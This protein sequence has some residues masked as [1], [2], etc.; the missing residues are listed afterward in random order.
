MTCSRNFR[1]VVQAGCLGLI[2]AL[3]VVG[4]GGSESPGPKPD[5][6][7]GSEVGTAKPNLNAT[8]A[9]V[10]LGSVDVGTTSKA[11]TV[12]I[13]NTGNAA[14]TITVTPSGVGI[15]AAGCTGSLAV[16]GSCT[17]S[18][19]ATPTA[20]G[21]IIG[22]VAVSAA[23]GNTVNIAVTG[24][25]VPVGAFS[26]APTAIPLGDLAVGSAVPVSITVTAQA[27]LTGLTTGVQGTNLKLDTGL[28]TC[29]ATLDA[30]ASCVVAATFTAGAVGPA[31]TDAIVVTQGGVSKSVPVSA[32]ILSP[33]KLAATPVKA[34]LAAKPGETA[35]QE[36]QIGNIGG[37][38]TGTI[39]VA[40]TGASFTVKSE[41]CTIVTLGAAKFCAVTISYTPAATVTTGTLTV[42]DKGPGASVATVALT[43]TPNVSPLKIAGGPSLGSVAPG[44][45]GAEV[46]FTVTN[47]G[48]APTGPLAATVNS[49][50]VAKSSDTCVTKATLN[51]DETCTVGLKLAPPAGTAAQAVSGLLTVT[52]TVGPVAASFTGAVVTNATLSANPAA[53]T[54][55][56]VPVNQTSTVQSVTITNT[57]ATATGTLV[58]TLAGAGAAQVAKTA[59]TCTG[60]LAPAATCTVS[61]QY[62]P[63]D[64]TGVNGTISVTDG[65]TASASVP[66]SGTGLTPT[67]L[68]VSSDSAGSSVLS[69]LSFT[70][71][72]VGYGKPL[73]PYYV[74]A[75]STAT[76][77]SGAI[78]ALIGGTN[79]TDFAIKTNGCTNALQPSAS[80]PLTLTFTPG[81]VGARVATLTVTGAKGGVWTVQLTGTGLALVEIKPLGCAH[82][83]GTS[84]AADFAAGTATGLD[85]GKRTLG[86]AGD[87]CKYTA[88]VRGATAPAAITT[89]A[90]VALATSTPADFRNVT[91]TGFQTGG[92]VITGSDVNPCNGQGNGQALGLVKDLGVP[93]ADA[94]GAWVD[95][96]LAASDAT[97]LTGQWECPFYVQ[98]T[99]Q[100]SKGAKTAAVTLS[101]SA[102]GSDPKTLT[103]EA[104][105]PL[106]FDADKTFATAVGTTS[107]TQNLVLTNN[108]VA[109]E[110]KLT[111]VLGGANAGDFG[112][113]ADGC[114]GNSPAAG[115]TCTVTVAFAPTSTGTK[116]AT[117]TVTSA[118]SSETASATLTGTASATYTLTL[119]PAS[120][121]TAPISFGSVAQAAASEYRTFTITNPAG[122]GLT[123]KLT[124]G[125][126]SCSAN[127]DSAGNFTL[128]TLASS[129]TGYPT[130]SC[131][132]RDTTQLAGGTACTIQARFNPVNTS[133]PSASVPRTAQLWVCVAGTHTLTASL[134]GIATPQLTVSGAALTTVAGVTTADFGTVAKAGTKSLS[135][136][137]TNNGLAPATLTIPATLADSAG[138]DGSFTIATDSGCGATLAAGVSCTVKYTVTAAA[139]TPG[140]PAAITAVSTINPATPVSVS[141]SLTA[142]AVDP[143]DIVLYGV[144][145][146]AN[147]PGSYVEFGKLPIN[148]AAPNGS[149]IVTLWFKNQGGVPG[150]GLALN[151][152]NGDATDT[153]AFALVAENKGTCDALT[154]GE[155][156]PNALC[157]VRLRFKP[158][159]IGNKT[160]QLTLTATD[161]APVFLR[162][163]A[164]ANPA[165][166]LTVTV[167]GGTDTVYTFPATAIAAS[168]S[169]YLQLQNAGSVA[170]TQPFGA[171]GGQFSDFVVTGEASGAATACG[172]SAG[173]VTV[174]ASGLCQVKVTFTPGTPWLETTRYRWSA[175]ETG[176]GA[177]NNARVFGLI[178]EA[179]QP[180]KLEL[181]A[182]GS[183][184]TK[185]DANL[186][187]VDFGQILAD[188]S[189]SVVFTIKNVGGTATTG[190]PALT[191]GVDAVAFTQQSSS[192]CTAALE[193]N[194]TCTVTV[195]TLNTLAVGAKGNTA[196]S[197][198]TATE[199]SAT[200]SSAYTLKAAVVAA[201]SLKVSPSADQSLGSVA[202]GATS[203]PATVTITNGNA[204]ETSANRQDLSGL[205][206]TLSN[207]TDFVVGYGT[208]AGT[209]GA[210]MAAST[211]G[212]FTLTGGASCTITISLAPATVGA[213]E[214]TVT[215]ASGTKTASVKFTGTGVGSLAI[216]PVSTSAAPVSANT[217]VTLTVTNSSASATGVLRTALAGANYVVTTDN[218]YGQTVAAGGNCTMVVTFIGTLSATA[219]TATVTVTDG[220][221]TASATAYLSA[222]S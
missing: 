38:P 212:T 122:G 171:V 210:L 197:T 152:T 4:C 215:V 97:H 174:P 59:D 96:T 124:Y 17:I 192:T 117:V 184:T 140:V 93:T 148:S 57:G 181:T 74:V 89:T 188:T 204:G 132:D 178:G 219:Q 43:G 179:K 65:G 167:V 105:G 101:G 92:Q 104:V 37:L 198:A 66:M 187:T 185:V 155:L 51:K 58:V 80:C 203:S 47:T 220:S 196:T 25:A 95:S 91:V 189:S 77:D 134:S 128:Y 161:S 84:L 166:G 145:G 39:T 79:A 170:Y 53:V 173:A 35:D 108:G 1:R 206:I 207:S 125:I 98:F 142:T 33:A 194:A 30:G 54:F 27:A 102:G 200:S 143:A 28:S 118:S 109:A 159:T 176:P 68:V 163:E 165:P 3:T 70:E 7:V 67:G 121:A 156:A 90:A 144:T 75:S 52:S 147:A 120:T 82:V 151:L 15:S 135:F 193:V 48:T 149:G 133:A 20:V 99:P 190:I 69:T 216:A 211:D 31:T 217:P 222:K 123:G 26:V 8:P 63:T 214:S 180:A 103:G 41:T 150:T 86:K 55:G 21:T 76:S 44:L 137:L 100:T 83:D 202:V 205:A 112:I 208:A 115:T 12:T 46:I 209:C 73:G 13:T 81:G 183:G 71:V 50:L 6:G 40:V 153:S 56:S 29:K 191:R 201:S 18:I 186:L 126:G 119:T 154:G 85:F 45:T 94:A 60:T 42:T 127:S 78:T 36:I 22:S 177:P 130:G 10:P 160:A 129:S 218:C 2:G 111:I 136:T 139:G 61:V 14:G 146:N 107:A 87:V 164:V 72:V 195:A 24:Q 199:A 62:S 88:I 49:A 182:T 213:L 114:S 172:Y 5:S 9:T 158:T 32:T 169:V 221:P 16:N 168:T 34:E 113:V 64:T 175:I 106:Q 110:G 138:T 23:G 19:T 131:G 162:G 157:S 141:V 11:G 116:T